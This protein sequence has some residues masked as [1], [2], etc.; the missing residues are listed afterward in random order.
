MTMT[1]GTTP[2]LL[3][4]ALLK[5]YG[6]DYDAWPEIYSKIS[7]KDTTDKY[8]D[9]IQGLAGFGAAG[10]K[11]EGNSVLFDDIKQGFQKEIVQ[12]AYGIGAKVTMEMMKFDQYGKMNKIPKGLA[13]SFRHTQE[14]MVADQ[15]NRA[16]TTATA[17]DGVAICST[18]HLFVGG[19]TFANRPVAAADLTMTT[20]ENAYVGISNFNDDRGLPMM[21]TV[22]KLLVSTADQMNAKKILNTAYAVG[23]NNNDVNVV[24]NEFQKV[25]LIVNPYFTDEDA[26][27]VST[28]E[29]ENGVQYIESMSADLQRDNVHNTRDLEMSLVGMFAVAFVDPRAIY[30]SPGA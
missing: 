1:T 4:P 2:E 13:K 27:F 19:G 6:D 7:N 10:V 23:T 5:L 30:G 12:V 11:T 18:A 8:F 3:W 15:Y 21:A 29:E 14:I 28:S 9:K 26:W 24:S 22:R 16:F 17:A 25:E 20:L